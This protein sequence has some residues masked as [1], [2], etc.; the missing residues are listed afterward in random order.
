M[1]DLPK[2]TQESQGE[3]TEDYL[4]AEARLKEGNETVAYESVRRDS[5]L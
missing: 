5:G 3:D 4:L 2:K 1:A